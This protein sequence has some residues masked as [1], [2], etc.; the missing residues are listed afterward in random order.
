MKTL[1]IARAQYKVEE[2]PLNLEEAQQAK[3]AFITSTTK[4]ILPVMQLNGHTIGNGQPG[5]I[6]T[7]LSKALQDYVQGQIK[8][9]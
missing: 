1:Q 9:L 3:E 6:T 4:H 8:L 5:A 2:R 7:G